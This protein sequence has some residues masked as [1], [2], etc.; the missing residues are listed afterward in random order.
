M[1]SMHITL[2]ILLITIIAFATGK[3]PFSVISSGIILALVLT[4]IRTP[5]EAADLSIQ[6]LSCLLP[7]LSL[8]QDLLR[9]S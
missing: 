2:I 7:C 5:A 9:Q 6:T 1:T 3:V 8:V 4:G